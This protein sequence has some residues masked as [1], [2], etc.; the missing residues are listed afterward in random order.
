MAGLIGMTGPGRRQ[1][2][3]RAHLAF[4]DRHDL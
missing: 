4:G 1:S 2:S 3:F